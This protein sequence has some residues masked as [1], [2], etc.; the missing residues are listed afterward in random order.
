MGDGIQEYNVTFTTD[1]ELVCR[2]DQCDLHTTTNILVTPLADRCSQPFSPAQFDSSGKRTK[3][4][5]ALCCTSDLTV[6]EFKALKGKIDA[7]NPNAKTAPECLRRTDNFRTD[8]Y[9]T[10]APLL[11]HTESVHPPTDR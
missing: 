9:S 11:T 1:R 4:A 6:D 7:F 3:A 5:T 8:L 10:G 2:H